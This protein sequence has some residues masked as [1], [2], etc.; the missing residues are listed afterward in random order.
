MSSPMKYF[1][2]PGYATSIQDIR[3][4]DDAVTPQTTIILGGG[5]LLFDRFWH[6][7]Q[8]L[9]DDSKSCKL[10]AWGIGQQLYS[11]ANAAKVKAFD[12][13][14]YLQ[15]FN[16]IGIRDY[17]LGYEW[18][19][20][21]SCMSPLF[22]Q[23]QTVTHD[24]VVFSHKKFQLKVDGFPRMTNNAQSFEDVI[25][26]LSS[27]DTVLTSSFH[28]AYWAT[29]LGKK[30]I[31]FPFSSKFETLRHQVALYPVKNWRKDRLTISLFKKKL[32]EF[33]YKN[34]YSSETEGWQKCLV[35]AQ[36]Y[37]N[38]LQD[39]RQA[40]IHFHQKVLNLLSV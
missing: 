24:F 8:R 6:R 31:A 20:C 19:P 5:G 3:N 30:V 34:K 1:E 7:I 36:K 2:F 17:D 12:Y 9:R 39:C 38:S 37:P 33:K 14:R 27:G 22:D 25:A 15:S 21:A 23:K 40:N 29:L 13:H 4:F 32:Y 28:G 18:V 11:T 35:D 26:F 16:L 10:V